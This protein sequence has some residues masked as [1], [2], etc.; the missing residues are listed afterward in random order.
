MEVVACNG[1][2]PPLDSNSPHSSSDGC[3]LLLGAATNA[4]GVSSN[5]SR[6]A[7]AGL[8]VAAGALEGGRFEDRVVIGFASY[9]LAPPKALL[10]V[11]GE[12]LLELP[13][14]YPG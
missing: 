8:F 4:L 6:S 12:K 14:L 7:T 11:S 3:G 5:E 9:G 10:E 1:C 13:L 2:T